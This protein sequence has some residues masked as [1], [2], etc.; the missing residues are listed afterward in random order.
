MR[1]TRDTV[2]DSA[3]TKRPQIEVY[4]EDGGW[5]AD[6]VDDAE[7]LELFGTTKLPTPFLE[8]TPIGNVIDTLMVLNPKCDVN[9]RMPF[10]TFDLDEFQ[11]DWE[12]ARPITA[13]T[14]LDDAFAAARKITGRRV[15][16]GDR[17]GKEYARTRG[18]VVPAGWDCV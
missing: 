2:L 11:T 8:A 12:S 3:V 10:A 7:T 4:L 6:M 9:P 13:H 15:I 1:I 18:Q 14:T 5:M 16:I 17:R